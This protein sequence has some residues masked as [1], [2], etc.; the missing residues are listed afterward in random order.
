MINIKIKESEA[1]I[2]SNMIEKVSSF[3]NSL[4]FRKK[5]AIIRE[6]R[7]MIPIWVESQPEI[8]SLRNSSP[9]SLA[10]QFGIPVDQVEPAI[11]AIVLA[12]VNSL[13]IDV[14]KIDKRTL[15]GGIKIKFMPATFRDLLTL[16][17]GHI[18][19]E[20]TDLHWL[21]WLLTEGFKVI[22][23]DFSF[24]FNRGRGR[25]EGG[26]MVNGGMWRV[27]PQYVGTI[28]DNFITRSLT[29]PRNEGQIQKIIQK[30][31]ER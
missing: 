22:V 26:Y 11:N 23:V 6:I 17:E 25:S 27:P 9:D 30:N 2:K 14:N 28:D 16:P 24:R 20:D 1:K 10:Y 19:Y 21:N 7:A 18:V 31:L 4:I 5:A 8:V 12:T 29:N 3:L 15:R 13:A